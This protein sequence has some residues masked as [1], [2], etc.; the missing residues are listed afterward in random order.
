MGRNYTALTVEG[1]LFQDSFNA[2]R[3]S[4]VLSMHTE[5]LIVGLPTPDFSM[6][7]NVICLAC[8]VVALAF[9]PIHS[10]ATKMIIVG[11][12]TT[13]TPRNFIKRLWNKIF[14]RG[15]A[16][17]EGAGAAPAAGDAA[18]IEARAPGARHLGDQPLLED[19][20]EE[21]END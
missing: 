21:E 12:T 10:V 2:T 13:T 14:R 11:R 17:A 4:Y 7:Y 8:T 15:Q 20:D 6:P 9:G 3:P 1:H 19:L 18:V 5:A 16:V